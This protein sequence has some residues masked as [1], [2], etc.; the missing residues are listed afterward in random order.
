MKRFLLKLRR[1]AILRA[2]RLCREWLGERALIIALAF[3]IGG[4]AAVAAALLHTLVTALEYLTLRID[5]GEFSEVPL[6]WQVVV[7]LLPLLGIALS[8][9]VQRTL[10]GARFA[11][12]LSPLILMLNRRRYSIP[13]SEIFTHMLSSGLAVGCGG[14]AGLEAPSVLTGSAIGSNIGSFL[15]IDRRHRSLLIGCGAAAAISAIFRSP[16]GGVLFAAEVLLPEFS[17]AAMVPMLIASAVATV[18]SRIISGDGGEL[19]LEIDAPWRTDAIPAYLLLGVLCAAVGV[20]VIRWAYFSSAWFKR[21]LPRTGS[22][23]LFGGLLLCGLLLIFPQLRG[24]GYIFIKQL[25]S[26]QTGALVSESP[27]LIFLGP[28]HTALALVVA[29][30]I[31]LKVVAC[32]LTID[33]GGDGG[34]FAPSMFIGAFTG[35]AFARLVNLT[36]VIELQEPNFV[37]VGM[38]G[39]FTAVMRAPLTGIFLIAEVTGGYLLLVPLMIVSAVSWFVSRFAEPNS[40]YYK[41]LVEGKLLVTDRD[42]AML[43]RLPVRLCMSS[44]F[45]TVDA[46]MTL[47]EFGRRLEDLPKAALFAVIGEGGR[48]QGIVRVEKI[49]PILL[50]TEL[51]RSLL[52][53]DVMEPPFGMVSVD[54]DLGWAMGNLDR[55]DLR[56]LPVADADGVFRGFVSRDTIFAKYRSLVRESDDF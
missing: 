18:V 28:N 1:V 49:L 33:S 6:D 10:G 29:A 35:F 16:V 56:E 26:G 2:V 9:L 12:S 43:R 15:G 38:C 46:G 27:L 21:R 30:G 34:I 17:V 40:V 7:F 4:A 54:D 45:Q 47:P 44:D 25:F 24:Q 39:V 8:A 22:R 32:S 3:F 31:F 48:L 55:Y 5:S 52:I 50:D 23:M 14:S 36:G 53:F 13:G 41:A 51:A 37:V 11:K 19:L 20:F 42:Q